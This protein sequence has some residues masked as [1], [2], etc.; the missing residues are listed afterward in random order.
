MIV[1]HGSSVDVKKIDLS[2]SSAN[3]DFG[4]G[5]YVTNIRKQAEQWAEQKREEN[6]RGFVS[7]F[8]F[9]DNAFFNKEYKT[10][11]F[12]EYTREWFDFVI[13]NRKND[14]DVSAHDYDIVE[15][16]VADDFTFREFDKFLAGETSEDVFFER[17][18]F[19]RDLS[20]Q[21][22]FCTSKSLE[23]IDRIN[24]KAYFKIEQIGDAITTYLTISDHFSEEESQD[25]YYNSEIFKN[26]SDES[27]GLYL[28]PWL[29]IYDM[30]K[31]E[32]GNTE[33]KQ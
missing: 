19:R 13:I 17:L 3:K 26:L 16:P 18:K 9:N 11:R 5:F 20:H 15:G 25:L 1:Y 14:L 30:L 23:T 27:T 21:I 33:A 28:K 24:L 22:C 8:K 10:L 32:M 6:A 31:L 12:E 2:K 29:K 7:E 4:K